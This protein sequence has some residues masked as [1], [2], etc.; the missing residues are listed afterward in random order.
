METVLIILLVLVLLSIGG[1]G[2]GRVVEPRSRPAGAGG[3]VKLSRRDVGAIV[4]AGVVLGV[5]GGAFVLLRGLPDWTLAVIA[6]CAFL[7]WPVVFWA[8]WSVGT[9]SAKSFLSGVEQGT[10]VVI[11]AGA[12]VADL[13]R[14]KSAALRETT[15]RPDVRLPASTRFEI[16]DVNPDGAGSVE[17]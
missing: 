4:A 9:K 14:E 15:S 8:G 17:L 3:G 10:G 5:L 1:A 12:S 7:S 11:R 2:A 6:L 13:R 16:V